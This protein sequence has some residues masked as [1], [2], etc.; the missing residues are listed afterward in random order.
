[1]KILSAHQSSFLPWLGFFHKIALSDIFLI[2]D[3][4]QFEKNSFSNRNKIRG[5]NGSFWLTVPVKL[6]GHL[7]KKII[8][9]EICENTIWRRKHLSAIEN[10][11][12]KAPYYEKYIP[13]FQN[14]YSQEWRSIA[15]LNGHMLKWLLKELGITTEI[16]RMSDFLFTKRKSDL[17]IEICQYFNANV[18]IFGTLGKNY[19]DVDKFNNNNIKIYFQEYRHPL[20]TQLYDP[21]IP[22]LSIID[23]LFNCGPGAG[24]ILING[25]ITKKQLQSMVINNSILTY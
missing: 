6:R 16:Y 1:M 11:Y 24:D 20:Y 19:A 17:I 18:Y 14:C 21:F 15:E 5:G 22:N 12:A 8:D 9:I 2:L 7:H 4:T 10:S 13:F 25:N 23:L 3:N